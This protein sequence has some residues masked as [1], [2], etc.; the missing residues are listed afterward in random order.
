M[1]IHFPPRSVHILSPGV[2]EMRPLIA[3]LCAALSATLT[4][5]ATPEHQ[6]VG[7]HTECKGRVYPFQTG[8]VISSKSLINLFDDMKKLY[9]VKYLLTRRVNQDLLE[10]TFGILRQMGSANDH[11]DPA[12]TFYD[13]NSLVSYAIDDNE[14]YFNILVASTGLALRQGT[15][16]HFFNILL[17]PLVWYPVCVSG[18]PGSITIW[19]SEHGQQH[20]DY[21]FQLPFT[22]VMVFGQDQDE[23]WS[24]NV[25]TFNSL[26]FATTASHP[27]IM[28]KRLSPGKRVDGD[29][30]C[31]SRRAEVG[32]AIIQYGTLLLPLDNFNERGT[33]SLTTLLVFISLYAQ[34]TASLPRTAYMK[35]IDLW[36][37]FC[38]AFLTLVIF[39]NLATST[40]TNTR[41][42]TAEGPFWWHPSGPVEQRNEAWSSKKLPNSS[43]Q[44]QQQQEQQRHEESRRKRKELVLKTASVVLGVTSLIFIIVY[45]TGAYITM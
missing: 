1:E 7:L 23:L 28:A 2:G 37:V 19:M 39:T 14:N 43:T 40:T 45:F 34:T 5:A 44:Q 21:N 33:M 9:S 8:I 22:G 20:Y 36:Y 6:D 4:F 18:Q 24:P 17:L 16:L 25:Q 38:I 32:A 15:S 35:R 42:T 12:I 31:A 41:G 27:V 11:P 30:Q 10:T 3:I 29:P 13:K 26:E